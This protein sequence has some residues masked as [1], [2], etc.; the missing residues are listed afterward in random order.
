MSEIRVVEYFH[1]TVKDSVGAGYRL[2]T[3]LADEGVNLVAFNAIPVGPYNVQM[4][5]FPEEP[6]LLVRT[7]SKTGLVLTGPQQAL[8]IQGDDRLGA[9]AEIHRR[10][11][12]AGVNVYS[13][14]AVTSGEGGYGYLVYLKSH[15]IEKAAA[16]LE[17]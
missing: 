8:L 9:L 15:D 14:T 1:T 5:L 6:E 16:T 3:E 12:D 13:S 10:L 11:F 4:M 17:I 7:A 2:L